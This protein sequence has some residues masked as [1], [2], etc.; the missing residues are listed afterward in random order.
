VRLEFGDCTLDRDTRELSRRGRVVH[1]EPKAYRL[2]ELLLD[3]RPKALSKD[4][5]QDA[6]WPKTY[7]S[8]LALSR[9]V[10]VLRSALG[11]ATKFPKLIRTVHGFGYAFSG[12][13][14]RSA[15]KGSRPSGSAFR[16]RI[17]M[18]EHQIALA[19]GENVIGRDPEAEVW[20]D[21]ASVSRR[22]ARI[23][24]GAEGATLEDLG[25]RNGT[26]LGGVRI[27]SPAKLSSGDSIRV[28]G[29]TLVFRATRGLGTTESE[30]SSHISGPR[31]RRR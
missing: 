9:L 23:L 10:S 14:K 27:E 19:E 8:E 12:D 7:V 2:L 28:G 25:S 16:C 31:D 17:V 22:H 4:E 11:D 1:I 26:Y 3:A 20:I 29:T 6:L 21:K 18:G 30:I 15:A 13:A 24:L 5:L